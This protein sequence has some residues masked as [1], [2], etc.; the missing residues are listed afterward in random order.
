M[1]DSILNGVIESS[2]SNDRS[3]K[4]RNFPGATVEDLRHHTVLIN[5]KQPMF[6]IAHA[7]TNNTFKFVTRDILNKLLQL[8]S[9]IQKKL[10]DA[11]ITI[12][13]P[14]LRSDNG[15][16]ALTARQ[17]T[18][19]LI[20]LKINF[21]DSRNITSKHLSLTDLHLNQAGSNLLTKDIISKLQKF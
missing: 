1:D 21:L 15:K 11:E 13:T 10:P 12:S 18:N 5:R 16:A 19:H 6:L 9:F 2:L 8:K 14:I 4:V 7:G 3:V 17:L 20:N